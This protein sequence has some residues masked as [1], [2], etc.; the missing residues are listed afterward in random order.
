MLA[1]NSKPAK[2]QPPCEDIDW[3]DEPDFIDI[4]TILF[5]EGGEFALENEVHC[6]PNNESNERRL[7]TRQNESERKKKETE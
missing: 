1:H 5:T 4:V 3:D 6:Q 2:R 7:T